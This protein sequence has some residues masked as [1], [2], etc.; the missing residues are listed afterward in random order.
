MVV[1][2]RAS[3]LPARLVVGYASGAYLPE[4]ARFVVT[5]A[6]AHSWAEVYFPGYGWVEFEPTGNR[7]EFTRPNELDM[8]AAQ[9]NPV[10]P[11]PHSKPSYI[12]N[13]WMILLWLA[14]ALGGLLAIFLIWL[15]VD[16]WRLRLLPP[17]FVITLLY[18]RLYYQGEKLLVLSS[19]SDTPYEFL[20]LLSQ[21][22]KALLPA[23][24]NSPTW[25]GLEENLRRIV[26]LYARSIYSP[27]SPGDHEK[28]NAMVIWKSLQPYL[29]KM[30]VKRIFGLIMGRENQRNRKK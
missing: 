24:A 25:H 23:V 29:W 13:P 1:L 27:H 16:S 12:G 2:A 19:A 20:A 4:T 7:P 22:V 18:R 30:Q 17:L 5:E 21:R 9:S 8:Q 10:M 15:L 28:L 6:D 26:D 11:L 3:G 14:I